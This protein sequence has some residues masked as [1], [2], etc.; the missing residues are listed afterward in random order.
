MSA[1]VQP[2]RLSSPFHELVI[3]LVRASPCLVSQLHRLAL[4]KR[5]PRGARLTEAD[6]EFPGWGAAPMRADLVRLVERPDRRPHRALIF[7]VQLTRD[8]DKGISWPFYLSAAR[9]RWRCPANLVVVTLTRAMA[10]WCARP[11]RLDEGDNVYQP[12]VIGPDQLPVITDIEQA[13][14]CPELAVLSAVAHRRHPEAVQAARAAL[15][16][17]TRLDRPRATM[18]TDFVLAHLDRAGFA[19]IKDLMLIEGYEYQSEVMRKPYQDGFEQGLERGLEQGRREALA[20]LLLTLLE[21]RFGALS[22]EA[23]ERVQH[24][25]ADRLTR[26]GASVLSVA[27]VDELLAS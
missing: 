12:M 6:L 8:S 17:C 10:R 7:E 18:Y 26:W 20:A 5:L 1:E 13:H 24:A 14:R 22:A 4:G 23:R 9:A 2:R 25:D 21:D 3:E 16:A 15:L 11:I 19:A 27:S